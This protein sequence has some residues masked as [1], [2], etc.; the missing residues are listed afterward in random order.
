MVRN[1]RFQFTPEPMYVY[2]PRGDGNGAALKLNLRLDATIGGDPGAEFVD[3]IDGGLFVDL[4]KQDGKTPDG[5][6]AK[7]GWQHEASLV[8]AK[9]CLPDVLGIL[10]AI[11][12]VRHFG[13]PVPTAL[14]PK[15]EA[16]AGKR[17]LTLSLFHKFGTSTSAITLAFAAEGSVFGISKS[18]ALRRS[19][20]LS[21][22]EELQLERY[23]E[24][25]LDGFLRMGVR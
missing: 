1:A 23:L 7:F 3:K 8:K 20:G 16:D 21:A 22:M 2:K 24:I 9:L 10:T 12:N 14:Q 13:K 18:R 11:R 4:A 6:F 17:K 25:A 5:K 15:A 19:I